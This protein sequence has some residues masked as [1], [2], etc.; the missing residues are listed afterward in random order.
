M[1]E[2]PS[3]VTTTFPLSPAQLGMWYAQRLDPEVPLS[4]AQYIDMR[5]RLDV[6]ALRRASL[7][8]AREFG[9][10]ILRLELRD[11][12]PTQTV[13]PALEPEVGLLDLCDR[14]DPVAAALDWMRAEV[15]AR[16][17]LPDGELGRSMLLRVGP[18]RYL[19]YTRMHHI[20]LDGFGSV[21]MLYRVAELYN[22]EMRGAP[23]PPAAAASLLD[24][25]ESEVAYRDSSRYAADEAYW[26]EQ[27]AGMPSR[28]SL[29]PAAAPA[30][31][32]ARE[33]R[34]ELPAE[35]A[36]RLTAAGD[37]FGVGAAALVMTAVS[38]Y[39]ARLTAT[40]DTVLS[41]AVSGR[42]TA[43]LRRS[44]GMVAN[45]VPLRVPVPRNA[46]VGDVVD[47]VRLAAS[48][49]LRHQRFRYE[50]IARESEPEFGRGIV[51]PVINIM[52]FPADVRIDGVDA[53]VHVLTSGPIDDLFVNF[54][55]HGAGAPIHVDFAANPRLYDQDSLDR[56]HARFLALLDSLLAADPGTAVAEL[57]YFT[58]DEAGLADGI[59]GP[60]A[61]PPRLLPDVLRDGLRAAGAHAVAVVHGERT[62][63]YRGLD[64]LSDRLA[65]T[66]VGR[67]LGPEAAVL[68]AM[69]RSVEAM[70]ALWA[71]AKSGAAYVPIGPGI[72]P[73][74]MRLIAAESGALLGLTNSDQAHEEFAE[75]SW[76]VVAQDGGYRVTGPDEETSSPAADAGK[77]TPE[78]PGMQRV[79]DEPDVVEA[80]G[81]GGRGPER[82]GMELW[83]AGEAQTE[84]MGLRPDNAAYLI[85]TSGSTGVP[86]GVVVTHRGLAGLVVAATEGHGLGAGGRVLQCLNPSFD[87]AVLEWLLAFASGATLV[88]ADG[89]PVVGGSLGRQIRKYGA[90][91]L[92]MTPSMLGTVGAEALESVVGVTVGGESCPPELVQRLGSGRVVRNSYG[93]TETS[94]AV[95]FTEALSPVRGPGLDGAYGPGVGSAIGTPV[96][97]VEL[98][99]LD[100]LLRPVP[101]GVIGELYVGGAALA[102]AYG[103]RA[104]L[105]AAHF[106][107]A[108]GG[109]RLYRTGDLARWAA[110]GLEYMGRT[111]F[112]VKVRGVRVEPGEIDGV[113]CDYPR[114]ERAVTVPRET[115][116]GTALAAYVVPVSGASV[117]EAELLDH[118]ARRL[119]PSM[120]P[121]TVTVLGALPLTS[122]GKI[123]RA[124]LPEPV[125]P[126]GARTASS[127]AEAT[128]CALF[129]DVLGGAEAGPETSFF[130]LGGDSVTAI[131]LVARAREAG[132]AFSARDV[133]DRRTPAGLALVARAPET[134][135]GVASGRPLV[136]VGEDEL[137]AWTERYGGVEDVWP[138]TPLQ[139]GLWF[140]ARL[141]EGGPD[142][143]AV[144][145]VIDLA[146]EL[147]PERL[148][149][150]AAR[151]VQ[152]HDVLRAAFV[153]GAESPVQLIVSRV[154]PP[155]RYLRL[156]DAAGGELDDLAAAE[157]RAPFVL[158]EPPLIRF[159]C[160]EHGQQ[161]FRLVIT[162]HHLVLDGWSMPLLFGELIALYEAGDDAEPDGPAPYRRYLEWLGSRDPEAA[163]SA[164]SA[165]LD[166][167]PGPTLVAPRALRGAVAA[168]TE[169]LDVPLP[170]GMSSRLREFAA[171]RELTLNTIVQTAWGLLLAD[172][173]GVG[174][175]VFGATVS[176]RAP[177]VPGAQR[178]I[179]ML[180]NTIPVRIAVDPAESAADL[181]ARV[182]RT[183][184]ALTGENPLGLDE[185][186]DI[187]GFGSLFDTTTVF[188]SYPVDERALTAAL[189]AGA[190]SVSGVRWHNG[191]HYPLSLAAYVRD[192]LR[193][194]VTYAPEHFGP[195][196]AEAIVHRLADLV[197]ALVEHPG[198]RTARLLS[199]APHPDDDGIWHG[200]AALA[201]ATLPELLVRN[202]DRAATAIVEGD[203]ELS[204][205]ELD[206]LS[207][208]LA[209]RL[210][211][212][213][214]APE[215][216]IPIVLPRSARWLIAAW[217]IAK[218]GAAFVLVDIASPDARI[219]AIAAQSGARLGI[220]TTSLRDRLPD[221]VCWLALEEEP[222]MPESVVMRESDLPVGDGDRVAPLRLD[223]PAYIVFTSGST[224][225]PKGV[226]ITHRGLANL[227]AGVVDRCRMVATSRVLHCHNPGFDASILVW[228]GAFAA[229]GIVV[230]APAG[231]NAGAELGELL[232]SSGATHMF[233]TPAVLDTLDDRALRG[234]EVVVTGGEVCSPA[235]VRRIGAGRLLVNSYGPAETSVAVTFTGAMEPDAAAAIGAPVPGVRLAVLDR[236]LRP[237]PSGGVGE[238]Y[239]RGPG[240]ARG[241]AGRPGATATGFVADPD[242]AGL[243][244]YRTGDLMRWT[245]GPE[246]PMLEYLG[247]GD[248]QVK[249]RGVRIEPAEVD[250]VLTAHP[251]VGAAVTVARSA[252]HGSTLLCTYVIAAPGRSLAAA[253]LTAWA[254][255]RLPPY[256]VPS[257]VTLLERLPRT[258]SGKVDLRALPEPRLSVAEYLAPVGTARVVA[259]VIGR[260][261][262]RGEIGAL[263]D[264]FALGGD[265]LS[266]TQVT[267]RL[268]AAL[269]TEVPVRMLFEA[270]VVRDLAGRL[271]AQGHEG[272]SPLLRPGPRPDPVPLSP[273]QQRMWFVNRYDSASPAYNIP[274][275]LRLSGRLDVAALR[276][277]L[278]DVI[279]RHE[280]LRTVYPE[281]DG[282]GHQR[283]LAPDS[284][285]PE[286]DPIEV[287]ADQAQAAVAATIG[288]GF[289]VTAAVPIRIRLFRIV[290]HGNDADQDAAARNGNG[291]KARGTTEGMPATRSSADLSAEWVDTGAGQVVVHPV[292]GTF[293]LSD[294]R[295]AG[296]R[297][298]AGSAEHILAVV[299]HHIATDGFSMGPLARDMTI[300]Y[301]ARARGQAP[302]W[303][304]VRVHYADYAIWQRARLG[305]EKNPDSLLAHQL[306]HWTRTLADLPDQL[307]LPTDR[308]RPPRPSYRAGEVKLRIE[309]ELVAR[310]TELA[311]RQHATAFMV[312]HAAL[313]VLLARTGGADDIVIGAPI[314]GR[315]RPELDE[316]VGMFVNTLVLRA[317]VRPDEGFDDLLQRI[318]RIDL[319]AF[320]HAELPFE[321]LVEA[322]A[323]DRSVARHPLVQV[324]M[325]FQN[326]EPVALTLPDLGV[327][328]VDLEQTA[329][330]FDLTFTIIEDATG[331]D[332][333]IGYATDLFDEGTALLLSRRLRRILSAVTAD[334]SKPVGDIGI[335]DAG[336]RAELLTRATPAAARPRVLADLLAAAVAENPDGTA[337]VCGR[338]ELSYRELDARSRDLAR[339]LARAGAGPESLVAVAIPRSIESVLAVWAVTR[340]GAAFVPVDPGYPA[341]RIERILGVSGARLGLTVGE[342]RDRLPGTVAWLSIDATGPDFVDEETIIG[343][344]P[345]RSS[346]SAYVIFTSGSTGEP[347]GVV[348]SHAGLANL[349]A[350][351]CERN[352]VTR[353]SRVLH[354]ASPSFDASVLE[355]VTA[356]GAAATLVVA[357]PSVY[358]GD[359]LTELLARERVTHIACTP[360]ALATV[361]P[362]G[363][364]HVRAVVTGGEPCPSDLVATWAAPGRQHFNDYGP[365]ETTVWAT[366]SEPLA[367]D[368]PVTI[369]T[370]APG[371]GVRVLDAR[372]HLV[373][374]GRVG[375]L[376]IT[377]IGLARGY[378]ERAAGTA[379]AFVAD[380]YGGPGE[381][382]YRTGDLVRPRVDRLEFVGRADQQVKLRGLRIELGDIEAALTADPDVA[383]AVAVLH[384]D[385]RSG[386]MLVA[387]V[388]GGPHLSADTV[389]RSLAH[390]IPSSML[391]SAI[392]VL[393]AMPRTA[394]GKLD[395]AAL[396][397]PDPAAARREYRA[398]GTDF[399][400][401]VAA[402]F[403][404][405]LGI[406]DVGV[407]DNF[408][409]LGGNSMVAIRLVARVRE[410]TGITMPVHWMFSDPTPAGIAARLG[411]LRDQPDLDPSLRI[412]LALRPTGHRAPVFCVHPAIGLAWC[413]A[414][415]VPHLD[416]HP[417]Y[418]LQS[419]GLADGGSAE[420]TVRELA[421]RYVEQIERLHILE[422]VVLL[423]YSAGGPIAHAMAV[424][425]RRRGARVGALI[426]LDGHAGAVDVAED[427]MPTPR[428]LL[429]EF[430]GI[431]L[432]E[433]ED[434][435]FARAAELLSGAATSGPDGA[436]QSGLFGAL[437]GDDLAHLY[438]D[439]RHLAAATSDHRPETFDGDLLFFASDDTGSAAGNSG[440]GESNAQTWRPYV[441]G[442]IRE[443]RVPVGHNQLTGPEATGVIGPILREYL[444]DLGL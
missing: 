245:A 295:A 199:D 19:W 327:T 6:A 393:D 56:H 356:A 22:A 113:L 329:T 21:T 83:G 16:V 378:F 51:G 72:P 251:D 122:N 345:V 259:D 189:G 85:F 291:P 389:K 32:R 266:A 224:G 382:M 127:A 146:G 58:P 305:E 298:S 256:M 161:R 376:Y 207:N 204:Y 360:S 185:I 123:D 135:G 249:V 193:L 381:R 415:F 407:D 180:V 167:L 217:A 293:G 341:E 296:N 385:Q 444:R 253:G 213:G 29:V 333:R 79:A 139:R 96:P 233:S 275:V 61:P 43:L 282:T 195:G 90:T 223:H 264:F 231:V 325:I 66:L 402:G 339:R 212:L 246:R 30:G 214:A 236:W 364:D 46:T 254:A 391:P 379:G 371:M 320:G 192:G 186:Q 420:R 234:L 11:G 260:V 308:P 87:A 59:H 272:A 252:A 441:T 31:P 330:R 3:P 175:V 107:A 103:G 34:H 94:V 351:Q 225:T 50:D 365:T 250:A 49:A 426:M 144:Q 12:V 131:D 158:D 401:A 80:R 159:L 347:K 24:V 316:V 396:P 75:L 196:R 274:I 261:L 210:I 418:G 357:P 166:G 311:H 374:P 353:E 239:V 358:A 238:L 77:P 187:T 203:R 62:L 64:E 218:S 386:P 377:G 442:E 432:P 17:E 170:E 116:R 44:G 433:D 134:S 138:L 174:D 227:A 304:P 297:N 168:A 265:S 279:A 108:P 104:G 326:L 172:L 39:Y 301:H 155:W 359:R 302:Q 440:S 73:D 163:R 406:A 237:V 283:I 290:G 97:G 263:D 437:T 363:L 92:C 15:V 65:R 18:D 285:V 350:A 216:A 84:R 422:P 421:V 344:R 7:V 397:A 232:V 120:V 409:D 200:P 109:S 81:V 323:P 310:I 70:I 190:V 307:A 148:A 400:R 336:E 110:D 348:V 215:S 95:S 294:L 289:D 431:V 42:T 129:A 47:A 373:P 173:T 63:T 143:Y 277:A 88:V 36:A 222:S 209:R 99:V 86:K 74:R 342:F 71:V 57:C 281:R 149:A 318:R 352:G 334:D 153:Q 178:M 162:N 314:A 439:F 181:L 392:L 101:R 82:P 416:D 288:T 429:A 117:G 269:N 206:T 183:Q 145:A 328:P 355:L 367:P 182:Q 317:R 313:A 105:S 366:G 111:D 2:D 125:A 270:P 4:E 37:R 332:M 286:L 438:S 280:T 78:L 150:A 106:V 312:L 45:I 68:V 55:Q 284:A 179:G 322:L 26:R 33:T 177:E 156:P 164:W 171:G 1:F 324:M 208:R 346:N 76:I 443:H 219:A 354:V 154:Q 10:G 271:D 303:P 147:E 403:E 194:V 126:Q 384:E 121:A 370:P 427:Q 140:Q 229:G 93:P 132:Y 142:H 413:Y 423:G 394:N 52:M 165:A 257:A 60:A 27:T 98:H 160:I 14:A 276:A 136:E 114:I 188:E 38:L 306:D 292:D 436:G 28:C 404:A 191:T 343:R 89:D 287:T 54:Y 321:R 255:D 267:A 151:L 221:T 124:A 273:A 362:A 119:P 228:L 424:E 405:V 309:P 25:H 315:G 419:P 23:A 408:F 157:L 430:G 211:R 383:Q 368:G 235:L 241:Y 9:C 338:E 335:L 226:V 337:V 428:M 387:Y 20:L 349:A 410:H 331:W 244:M 369:G 169:D 414:G 100:R 398:P 118:L 13:D 69:P 434:V 299:V 137:A 8:A 395:R 243:R 435:T 248:S 130:A 242:E 205:A 425:M 41:L 399:E 53:R 198:R 319:D 176:G 115:G 375:E 40:T 197:T 91:H 258:P 67:G 268:A 412:L 48:G 388:T 202:A 230:V 184:G 112:Q 141:T 5:G 361:D 220:T 372:L 240:L 262:H 247:R 340:S 201:P 380:P 35:L 411:D 300:A 133:F 102:R 417:V 390:R 152:R 278:G 128:L